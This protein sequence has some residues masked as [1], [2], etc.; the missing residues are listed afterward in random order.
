MTVFNLIPC[1]IKVIA[2]ASGAGSIV[3]M[4]RSSRACQAEGSGPSSTVLPGA[5]S[6]AQL[7]AGLL[8]RSWRGWIPETRRNNQRCDVFLRKLHKGFFISAQECKF[9]P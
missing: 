1:A 4:G 7:P 6:A 3:L 8:L 9:M 5:G 2:C